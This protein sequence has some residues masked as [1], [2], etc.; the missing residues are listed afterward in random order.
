LV[1]LLIIKLFIFSLIFSNHTFS[2][3]INLVAEVFPPQTH[4]N[5]T[6]QQFD[7]AKAIFEPLGYKVN[8]DVYPYRRV[9][10]LL[11]N[12]QVDVAVGVSK[13]N[14]TELLFSEQ[15]HDSD[16]LVAIYPK[17]SNLIWQ[18]VASFKDKRLLFIA[19]LTE[20]L[21]KGVDLSSNEVSEVN[22]RLQALKKL[23]MG[24]DDFLIDCE[25][26]FLL[27]EVKPYRSRFNVKNI[28][29]IKI[30]AAFSNTEKGLKLKEIWNNEFPKF[31]KTDKAREIYKKWGLMREYGIL[32]K[33]IKEYEPSFFF[34]K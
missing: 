7:I 31:I 21:S 10:Y 20:G 9:I 3:T 15:A 6:G 33:Q 29:F 4:S 24:R 30:Y 28:G 14:N 25:C 13:V 34:P 27:D 2:E 11:E 23:Q 1:K 18:D 5:G 12:K 32:Q 8:I 19:G 16:N 26:G 22:T 17:N